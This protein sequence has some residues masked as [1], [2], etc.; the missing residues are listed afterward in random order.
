MD[1]HTTGYRQR[2]GGQN[3]AYRS[4]HRHR[5]EPSG[6]AAGGFFALVYALA[7]RRS[8]KGLRLIRSFGRDHDPVEPP[9]LVELFNHAGFTGVATHHL[10]TNVVAGVGQA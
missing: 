5:I 2:S 10:T 7:T 6:H 3:P 9:T 4:T 8:E 1:G